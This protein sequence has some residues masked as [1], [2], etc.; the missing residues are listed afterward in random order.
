MSEWREVSLGEG[1]DVLHGY[2][3]KGEHFRHEGELIVLTPGNFFDEGGF[4]PKSGKEKYYDGPFPS[5]FL[6]TSGDVVVAMTEQVQGLLGSSATIPEDGVYLHNQRIG[7]VRI[8]NPDL[9]DERFVYHLMNTPVVRHQLQATATGSK[10][11]H[12]APERIKAVQAPVPCVVVQRQS[13]SILDAVDG[14]IEN[15]RR[16]VELLEKMARAI[17]R[18]W[19]IRFRYPGHQDVPLVDSPLGPIP[20]GWRIVP[21]AELAAVTMG[22]SPKSEFYNTDG[23]GKPFHQGVADF[24]FHFPTHRTYC[25]LGARLA[26]DGDVLVSVRAPVGRINVANT[27][28]VIGRGLAALR[29]KLGCQSLLL[30]GLKEVFAEEDSMGGGTIFKAIGKKELEQLQMVRPPQALAAAADEALASPFGLIRSLSFTNCRLVSI[31]DLLRPR[32][33][34][35]KIDVSHIGLNVVT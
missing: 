12:T 21:L 8:T 3:L 19:F 4:K 5:R 18:E 15:N 24:G 33:I 35:G 31:R 25:T 27:T 14:L 30:A 11:R 13:A 6:L 9:F 32:L 1:L 22:Q 7:L 26:H 23:V 20:E 17:Y 10:V 2:A 16:R 29:S 34:T 28:L